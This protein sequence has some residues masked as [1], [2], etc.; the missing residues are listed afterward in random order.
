MVGELIVV[1]MLYTK[2]IMD[3]RMERAVIRE[4]NRAMIEKIQL[5]SVVE[6]AISTAKASKQQQQGTPS[7]P[8]PIGE[9][10]N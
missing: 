6:S 9:Y 3:G 1:V 2:S 4:R 8:P 5:L 7:N 10:W